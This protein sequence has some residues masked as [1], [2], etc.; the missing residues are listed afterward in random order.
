MTLEEFRKLGESLYHKL[1]LPTWPVGITYIKSLEEI[2]EDTVDDDST[3]EA[4]HQ[5]AKELLEQG[6]VVAAWHVLA[7]H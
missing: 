5:A 6:K 3:M 4:R 2:P 1:H 7:G